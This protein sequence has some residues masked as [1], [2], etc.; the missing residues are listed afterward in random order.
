MKKAILCL[1]AGFIIF[2]GFSLQKGKMPSDNDR[3]IRVQCPVK[4]VDGVT[5]PDLSDDFYKLGLAF[6]MKYNN[7]DP[8][9]ADKVILIRVPAENEAEVV[10]ALKKIFKRVNV[11]G[12]E[13]MPPKADMERVRGKGKNENKNSNSAFCRGCGIFLQRGLRGA[14]KSSGLGFDA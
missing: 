2:S 3:V 11:I 7:K 8:K 10:N 4:T 1:M 12:A 13:P 14:D 9:K 6:T 5:K